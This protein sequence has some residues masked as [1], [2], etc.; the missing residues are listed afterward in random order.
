MTIGTHDAD[1]FACFDQAAGIIEQDLWAKGLANALYLKHV[2][3]QRVSY[4]FLDLWRVKRHGAGRDFDAGKALKMIRMLFVFLLAAALMWIV[5]YSDTKGWIPGDQPRKPYLQQVAG[6]RAIVAWRTSQRLFDEPRLEWGFVQE[7][8]EDPE[9]WNETRGSTVTSSVDDRYCDHQVVLTGL[10]PRREIRYRVFNGESS[11]GEGQFRSAPVQNYDGPIKIWV[12]G[13]SGTGE[14]IQYGVRDS[15]VEYLGDTT[16]DMFIH[17]GDMAYSRGRDG[18]FTSRFFRPYRSI[19]SSVSCWPAPGNHEM[20]SADSATQSGPYFEAYVMPKDGECGGLSSGT[21]AYYSFDYGPIHVVSLDSSDD[22]IEPD[23]VM[24]SWLE[25][26]LASTDKKWII[27]FFHHPPYTRGSHNSSNWKDSRGRLVKMREIA[28]PVLEAGGVDLVLAGHS[29]VYERS[30]LIQ[31]VY[32]YGEAPAHPVTDRELIES[33]GK[34]L[35]WAEDRY[36]QKNS[37]GTVYIVIGN[38][39]ASVRNSGEHPVMVNTQSVHGSG[40]ITVDG[41]ELLFESVSIDGEVIDRLVIDRS[42]QGS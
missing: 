18:E 42:S 2:L 17:V 30:A 29:H 20:K 38:G 33:E 40:L 16:L 35:Q 23:G 8:G 36:D 34:I 22:A 5:R 41:D 6:D 32:G 27:A 12:L 37:F 3:S 28:L 21:E 15:M 19:I 9:Q 7:S 25:E 11:V 13:D 39:G 1:L 31:G 4:R 26:D 10:P 24:L 14:P